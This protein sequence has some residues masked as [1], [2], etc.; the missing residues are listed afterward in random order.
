MSRIKGFNTKP[1]LLVRSALHKKGLRFRIHTADLPG[2]PDII[3]PKYKAAIFV[4]G[5]FWHRHKKCK[6][7]YTPKSRL[8]FWQNKFEE[9]VIRDEK[10]EKE[11]KKMGWKI[12]VIWECEIENAALLEKIVVRIISALILQHP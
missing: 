3:L 5:C 8:D 2:K 7:A 9:N 11:L 4:H 12:F 6:K 10:K 1:E